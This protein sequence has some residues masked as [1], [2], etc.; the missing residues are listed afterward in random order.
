[1]RLQAGYAHVKTENQNTNV[2]S[3]ANAIKGRFV[4]PLGPGGTL[5]ATARYYKL[6]VDDIFVDIAEP[7]TPGGPT[8]GQTYQQF[9]PSF[10]E[11]DFV[12]QSVRN[13]EP[14]E[15]KLD[16]SKRL[17]RRNNLQLTYKYQQVQR[18]HFEVDKT[19]T[20]LI[21]AAY[22][23]RSGRQFRFRVQGEYAWITDPFAAIHAAGPQ[24]ILLNP[25]PNP[26]PA[27]R[28]YYDMYRSRA[29][30]LS[31]LPD[32][33]SMLFGMATWSP[34]GRF[35]LNA[36]MRWRDQSNK[37]LTVSEWNRDVFNPGLEMWWMPGTQVTVSAGY[38]YLR[39]ISKTLLSVLA[40]D[41]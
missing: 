13:R 4:M 37:S 14:V 28:Q 31:S 9:Y 15:L 34:S 10:G 41:G 22:R 39:D 23:G 6:S 25:S 18:E 40:F 3:I 5:A 1:M 38:D 35:S 24:L 19:T 7:V 8:A 20:N 30:N 29:W 2:R 16:W 27:G 32:R 12:R 33:A 36:H 26:F 11:V 17:G 21:R